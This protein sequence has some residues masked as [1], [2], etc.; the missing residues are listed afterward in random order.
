[1]SEEIFSTDG[2]HTSMTGVHSF[3]RLLQ[4]LHSV[5]YYFKSNYGIKLQ[6]R[7]VFKSVS[8]TNQRFFVIFYNSFFS[9]FFF[10]LKESP[11][12]IQNHTW[13]RNEKI[14]SDK[15][16]KNNYRIIRRTICRT[17]N[18]IHENNS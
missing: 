6:Q 2:G 18:K 4:M 3:E 12:M 5:I 11:N 10:T 7:N 13:S 15:F 16:P 14:R 17:C 9:E 8:V 1:M